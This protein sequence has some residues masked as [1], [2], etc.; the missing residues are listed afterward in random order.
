MPPPAFYQRKLVLKI[1][2]VGFLLLGTGCTD[3]K[4]ISA[5]IQLSGDGKSV[6]DTYSNYMTTTAEL[7]ASVCELNAFSTML[8]MRK[9]GVTVSTFEATATDCDAWKQS[10]TSYRKLRDW[11]KDAQAVS[12]TY[13]ALARLTSDSS[14]NDVQK[15]LDGLASEIANDAKLAVNPHVAAALDAV[16]K[17]IVEHK[18]AQG[19]EHFAQIMQGVPEALLATL[20]N[21]AR[22]EFFQTEY[23][24]YDQKSGEARDQAYKFQTVDALDGV[25]KFTARLGLKLVVTNPS[26]PYFAAFSKRYIDRV[27]VSETGK[28]AYDQLVVSLKNLSA[29]THNLATSGQ[30]VPTFRDDLSDLKDLIATLKTIA[31]PESS[32]SLK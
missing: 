7:H 4:V 2:V 19:I 5:A 20:T 30:Q 21:D 28:Q 16:S 1:A 32:A 26:D 18:E 27:Q 10:D 17:A 31:H 13:A 14:V 25:D 6:A 3:K 22:P 24:E 23:R 9:G 8:A 29:E 11:A 12:K 15:S